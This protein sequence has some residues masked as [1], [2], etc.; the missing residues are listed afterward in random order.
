MAVQQIVFTV[1]A[2]FH[3]FFTVVWIGGLFTLALIVLPAA[4]KAWG[5]G[6]QVKQL[7]EA[8][9]KRLSP[10]VYV[11]IVGLLLTG[12]LLARRNPAFG[13]LFS[14]ANPYT[15]SLAIKH[16]LMLAMVAVTLVR[17]VALRPRG[18]P[19]TPREEKLSL[20][21]LLVNAALGLL[22]LLLS[23]L[24][25]ALAVGGLAS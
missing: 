25:A 4:K 19:R 17:S 5:P 14:F 15:A 7:L 22:V 8:I 6:P 2:F 10:L 3:D 16:L 1:V 11:S 12:V 18:R 9:Q 24:T 23:A 20:A 21:L 13:G